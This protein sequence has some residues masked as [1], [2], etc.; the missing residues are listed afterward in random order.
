MLGRP[1]E[2]TDARLQPPLGTVRDAT[3]SAFACHDEVTHSMALSRS[4]VSSISGMSVSYLRQA[5]C[6]LGVTGSTE[7]DEVA[8]R[9]VGELQP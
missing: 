8:G 1:K 6:D 7:G 2:L 4:Q 9:G 5:V 3:G